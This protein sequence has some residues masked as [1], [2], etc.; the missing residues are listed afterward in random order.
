[1]S[2]VQLK[3]GQETL[4]CTVP[5]AR[6]LRPRPA[7][8]QAAP[9]ALVRTALARPLGTPPLEALV[10]PGEQVVIVTSDIT[11]YTGSEHYLP[12]LVEHLNACGVADAD[13]TLVVALG[14]HRAQSEAEHRKIMGPL[15]GRIKV[16]DHDCDNPAE[17]VTLGETRGG[18]PVSVNRRVA[19]ADRVIVT[20]TVGFHYFAGFGGGRKGLVPGVASRATCMATHFGVFNPPEIGGKH[21]RAVT[22]VLDGNPV[23]EAILEAAR[24]IAPDFLFNTVLAPDKEML[25]VFCGDL[26]AAHLA[27]C[28]LCR[29]LYQ[30]ELDEPADL[31]VVSCGGYPKD[32]NFIQAHKALDYGVRA[33]RPGGTLILLA[34]C[35]D[36]FGN[37]TFFDWF[38]YQDLHEFETA[39]RRNYEINGQTAHATLT[40]ARN[41][42]VILVSELSAA[43]TAAMG[44]EKAADLDAALTLAQPGLPPAPRAVII[45]DGGSVLPHCRG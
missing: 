15:H 44:M 31:A 45:P 40:K 1:M 13:L 22:G 17:L 29:D 42:R 23:H 14:I 41:F 30:V 4:S 8:P 33:L 11:R 24:M 7:T 12:V 25:A 9:D 38:R 37:K 19:E 21:P 5:G 16:V 28:D 20:G 26:E 36:G 43:Q 18:I 6:V 39:L 34:A 3:Y 10:K 2:V 32:I 27:G 35:A